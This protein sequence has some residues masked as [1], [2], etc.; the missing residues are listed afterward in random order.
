[1][2]RLVCWGLSLSLSIAG[3]EVDVE[4]F[5]VFFSLSHS[6]SSE[7]GDEDD[8]DDVMVVVVWC[9]EMV[10]CT[11]SLQ[12][13]IRREKKITTTQPEILW[14]GPSYAKEE[15]QRYIEGRKMKF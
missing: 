1:L 7:D 5:L 12:P 8:C 2:R 9:Y 6:L 3:A 14:S 13:N 11:H 4:F 15:K 10:H